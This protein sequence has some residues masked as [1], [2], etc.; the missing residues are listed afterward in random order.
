MNS[1]MDKEESNLHNHLD[2]H[3]HIE[4]GTPCSDFPEQ[5]LQAFHLLPSE[6]ETQYLTINKLKLVI[7]NMSLTKVL[8]TSLSQNNP[9]ISSV[10][11]DISYTV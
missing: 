1:S 8:G 9:N 4:V 5:P 10:T 7:F 11:V 3:N 2:L 6:T